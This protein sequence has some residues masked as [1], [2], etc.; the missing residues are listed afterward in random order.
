MP[1]HSVC[2]RRGLEP[3]LVASLLDLALRRIQL[4][5]EVALQMPHGAHSACGKVK[6]KQARC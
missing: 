1:M 6:A 2:R 3:C 4:L 5:G